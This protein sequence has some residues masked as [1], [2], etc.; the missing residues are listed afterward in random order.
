[1][2]IC[3]L[4]YSFYESD[5]RIRQY[6]TALLHRGDVVDVIALRRMGG[7][8]HEMVDG[9]RVT[10]IQRRHVTER[11]RLSYL[12][13]ILCFLFRAAVVLAWRQLRSP[14]DFIHVHSV[15]DF[16]V[17]AAVVP[18]LFGV[19]VIVDLHDLLP[20]LY[21]GKFGNRRGG[22]FQLLVVVERL[23]AA[24]ADHVIVANDIWHQRLISR[25]VRP[26][27]CSTIRNYPDTNLFRA[28]QQRSSDERFL[29]VYP[30]SLNW[31]QGV[32]IAIH[33]FAAVAERLGNAEFHIY[34]EGASKRELEALVQQLTMQDRIF[35]HPMLPVQQIAEVMAEADIAIEPKRTRSV[36]GTE[37][38]SMKILE[39]MAAGVPVIASATVVHR[40]YYDDSLV[41]FFHDDSIEELATCILLLK[42]HPEIRTALIANGAAYIRENNWGVKAGEYLAI[43]DGLISSRADACQAVAGNAVTRL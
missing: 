3:M 13:K 38:L 10:R 27:K 37:A 18:K 30:G 42:E 6:A 15:P 41:H 31:H 32:D 16:L 33:A 12:F 25:S 8:R 34:G 7:C 11:H 26:D 43:V 5:A 35:L 39:F 23:S 4:A 14:Y 2:R 21:A 40:Y 1:M 20:E 36:F 19:P 17:F 22:T 24:F 28:R 9:V 29:I